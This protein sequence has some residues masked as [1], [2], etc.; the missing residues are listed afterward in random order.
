MFYS[1]LQL[2]KPNVTKTVMNGTFPKL[3]QNKQTLKTAPKQEYFT[4]FTDSTF[5]ELRM[6]FVF[7]KFW[8]IILK[9]KSIKSL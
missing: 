5:V 7:G 2:L 6:F 9:S 1:F 4:F 3:F 8:K